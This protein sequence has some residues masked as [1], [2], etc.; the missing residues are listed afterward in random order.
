MNARLA[1]VMRR[2]RETATK[3]RT[4]EEARQGRLAAVAETAVAGAD[5]RMRAIRRASRINAM[6]RG[7]EARARKM[8]AMPPSGWTSDDRSEIEALYAEAIRLEELTGVAHDVD[9]VTP[10]SR[11]GLH[12]AANMRVITAHA[13]R[14]KGAKTESPEPYCGDDQVGKLPR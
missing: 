5:E 10:L 11:G 3:A 7:G 2:A 14:S 9:H 4:A 6:A 1:E 8:G 12:I 13:N